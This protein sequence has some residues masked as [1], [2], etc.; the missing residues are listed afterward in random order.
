[1]FILL[2]FSVCLYTI[3]L[4]VGICVFHFYFLFFIL[5]SL[6]RRRKKHNMIHFQSISWQLPKK[7]G[8]LFGGTVAYFEDEQLAYF[9]S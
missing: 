3:D 5:F 4:Y 7:G 2:T 9:F 1:M 6:I 8:S